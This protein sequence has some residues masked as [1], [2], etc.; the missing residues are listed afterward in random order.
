M[1][2]FRNQLNLPF[3][4]CFVCSFKPTTFSECTFFGIDLNVDNVNI[5]K[6]HFLM[7]VR[8]FCIH[9]AFHD[10]DHFKLLKSH[11]EF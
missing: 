1:K 3:L 5:R 2:I 4:L 8:I 9:A 11:S 6:N 10:L 7:C